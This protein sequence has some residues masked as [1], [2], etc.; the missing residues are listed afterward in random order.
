MLQPVSRTFHGRDVFS[1]VAAHLAAGVALGALGAA[2]RPGRARAPRRPGP[3][4]RADALLEAEV[5]YVDR[6]GTSSWRCRR[7]SWAGCSRPGVAGRD[8]RPATTATTLRCAETFADVEDGEIVLYE[9]AAG[10]LAVAINRG[11]AAELTARR[12]RR[13]RWASNSLP[14][15][16]AKILD[17]WLEVL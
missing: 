9:D 8:R 16:T 13:P 10:L 3:H 2:A 12:G 1:P 4:G 14:R 17:P 5:Q 15:S 6:T 11:N 7:A